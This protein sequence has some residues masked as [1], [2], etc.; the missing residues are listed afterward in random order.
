MVYLL[1][2]TANQ[3]I[4]LSLYEGRYTLA[5]FTHYMF[6]IIRE[7]NSE[8][9]EKLNQVPAVI[10]DGSGYSHI[11]VT[12]STLTQAGRYR[13]VVY[14]QNSSTNIDDEDASIVGIVEIGYL[15]LT[16]NGTYYDV[17]ETTTANDI[18]ID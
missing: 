1:P 4:Y 16:D 13:Y 6:S 12:T 11:T 3:S 14:G 18:I 8:T 10:T 17:V 9:G 5:D 7:E 15:E 2:N